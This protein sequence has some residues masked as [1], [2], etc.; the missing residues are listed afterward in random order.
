MD[1]FDGRK[2]LLQAID[3]PAYARSDFF[4]RKK[5]ELGWR[6]QTCFLSLLDAIHH[7]RSKIELFKKARKELSYELSLKEETGGVL[8]GGLNHELLNDLECSVYDFQ[9][10]DIPPRSYTHVEILHI[11]EHSLIFINNR[12]GRMTK[13][14]NEKYFL[15]AIF[16]ES[17]VEGISIPVYSGFSISSDLPLF[18]FNRFKVSVM[19]LFLNSNKEELKALLKPTIRIA[20]RS[21]DLWN[22]EIALI[23]E[24][25][26]LHE[27]KGI[28]TFLRC[29]FFR[30]EDNFKL[31]NYPDDTNP[32]YY[33]EF[34]S[35]QQFARL[36]AD[37][38]NFLLP[39]VFGGEF[40]NDQIE[41]EEFVFENVDRIVS[42]EQLINPGMLDPCLEMLRRV[43]Q[44]L[45]TG[46]VHTG[47]YK[48]AF[49]AW[50]KVLELN[51]LAKFVKFS[52]IDRLLNTKI[53]IK[54]IDKT[55]KIYKEAFND[56][57]E[58]YQYYWE[59]FQIMALEL[60]KQ[61]K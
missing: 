12:F 21:L 24:E 52:D 43:E 41:K 40:P 4:R 1:L 51:G 56:K 10:M 39:L 45:L 6:K 44:P 53:K 58:K 32:E 8:K 34:Y 5:D 27:K 26:E 30:F 59:Q 11:F 57:P 31:L 18:D 28:Y 25:R 49:G 15:K 35:G 29:A 22:N 47:V 61:K 14:W 60:R 23:H 46:C 38:I 9:K 19:A 54:T 17:R 3:Y 16:D 48:K 42:L 2:I 37:T 50:L 13:I 20:K 36:T 55:G 7:Y 33:F